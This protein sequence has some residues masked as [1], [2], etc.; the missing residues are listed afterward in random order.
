MELL[1]MAVP[2]MALATFVARASQAIYSGVETLKYRYG[3]YSC[4]VSNSGVFNRHCI[5]LACLTVA[6][7]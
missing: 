4:A 7:K 3:C 5:S 1:S 2:A 6:S